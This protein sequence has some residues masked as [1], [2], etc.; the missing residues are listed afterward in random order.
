MSGTIVGETCESQ[1]YLEIVCQLHEMTIYQW[2][3][4]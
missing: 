4:C 2:H 3:Q 1:R